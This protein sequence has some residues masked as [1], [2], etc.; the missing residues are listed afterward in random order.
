M[1]V[2]SD[3]H[4]YEKHKYMK[5]NAY[6]GFLPFHWFKV[7]KVNIVKMAEFSSK[8]IVIIPCNKKWEW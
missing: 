3:P 5:Y 7:E 8:E 2:W 6:I 4:I 1:C